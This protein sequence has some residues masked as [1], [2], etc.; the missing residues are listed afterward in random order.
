[1]SQMLLT[2]LNLYWTQNISVKIHP[3]QTHYQMQTEM[4]VTEAPGVAKAHFFPMHKM[5]AAILL[6]NK[7]QQINQQS[8]WTEEQLCKEKKQGTRA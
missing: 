1:M 3:L 4:M 8:E 6:T 5:L 2:A 7:A